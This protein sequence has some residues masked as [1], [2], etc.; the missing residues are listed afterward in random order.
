MHLAKIS[1]FGFKSFAD[2]VELSFEPG[3]TAVVG[4]NGCGKSNISDA[5]RWALGEQSAKLLR[6]DRMEDCIFAGNSRRKP[7]G[8][9]EVSLTLTRN[10]GELGVDYEEVNVTRRLYRSGESEYLLNKIPCRLRDIHDLFIDTGLAGEPYALIEQGSIGSVVNARPT[11]RRVLIEEAAGIM[12]YKTKKRSALNK[13]EATEQNLLRIRDVIA[14]VE[15]QRNSLK[16]QANKAERYRE[17][18]RRATELKLYLK[19]REHAALWDELQT[20]LARLSP[21]QETLTGLRAGIAAT[22]ADLESRRLQALA[23]EQ[24]VA[25]A[26]EALYALRGQIDRDEAELR[27]LTQ[28]IEAARQRQ[29][30]NEATLASLG[31]RMRGLL[32]ELESGASRAIQQEQEVAALEAALAEE[33]QR[34]REAE[35]AVES[36]VAELERLRGQAAHQGT[37]LALKRNELATLV[38]R[39]RQMTAQAER[40]R[41]NRAEATTQREGAE[42][43]FSA[44]EARRL[45]VLER[46]GT[47]AAQRETAQVDAE[48]AREAR[49]RLEAEIAALTADVERQRGRLASLHELK[50]QFADFE[51]GNRLLL[52]AG[53]DRRVAGI[54]GSLAEVLDVAPRHEKAL[55][56]ILGAHLQGVRVRTWAEAKDALAHLFRSGQGR[57]TLVS[58]M[59]TGQ[60]TWGQQIRE[61]LALQ[62]ADLPKEL[63]G[64]SEGL[65]LDLLQTPQGSEPWVVNLL[66]DAVVVSDLDAA[67]AIAR[68]LPGPFT[69]AT[70]AGEVLTHRGTLTGGTPAPQGLLAQ[71][72]EARELE[73]ALATSELGQAGLREA[74]S[75]VSE[76]VATAERAV[77]AAATAER[78]AELDLLAIEKDLA[79]KR[80]EEA[81]L[82]QQ[83]ELFGIELQ[84][85]EAD[86]DR[87]AGEVDGLR[88]A[89]AQGEAEAE[90]LHRAIAARESAVAAL[91]QTREGLAAQ[92]AEKRVTLASRAAQRD[93]TLRDLARMRH[94]LET[95][96]AETARLTQESADLTAHQTGL[97]EVRGRLRESLVSLHRDEEAR[98]GALVEVQEARAAAQETIRQLEETLRTRRRE[99]GEIAEEIASLGTKR[100]ELKTA[101]THLEQSLW[102]DHNVSLPE[103]R[104][105]FAESTWEVEAAQAELE[106]L[107]AKLLEL[108]PANLGALEEYQALC[109]RHEFLTS[110]ATDLTSSVAS[111]RQAIA[112]INRTITTLFDSTLTTVNRHFDHYWRRLIGGGSAELR[113]VEPG[114]GEATEEPGVEML[115]RIPGKRATVLSLLSGGERALAALALLL[116]LFTTR[117]SPF[118]VLDEVD[119]PLDDVNVERFITLLR[120]MSQ[121]SQFIVISHNKRTMEAANILY[122][123]TMEEEG[124]SKVISVRMKAAA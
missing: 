12:K 5:V 27:N 86:L 59:P 38:E 116:A 89:V 101:M 113:L 47:L 32:A 43:S 17:L 16:R 63:R 103:L 54:L 105:R 62:L 120:E 93:E 21:R 109:Q 81:R 2:K 7:L 97:E 45:E 119:A 36:G 117:P 68:E 71:R 53:R 104:E 114:E 40:L 23:Q 51:E 26:Q 76:D 92:L 95:A 41:L 28:Q 96:E 3:I 100:G 19:F 15:R 111:L 31:E 49:R 61:E 55:E 90:G 122:G 110:Q 46:Q 50:W 66:A 121:A 33:G 82:S 52:Q 18:D 83:L 8:L 108:G 24:A 29:G 34:L 39:S 25:T 64:Q 56:A 74:L 79:A 88:A 69:I 75:L 102:Q 6:G 84:A 115:L 4:P 42:A 80:A 37:Q 9:A 35:A 72:R 78:Q 57:A 10:E 58:P 85:V 13:L 73:E 70:L 67:Q 99:E 118:C 48:R 22:E 44:D 30:E 91:R 14:E 107:R 106:E 94:D 87:I 123:I 77:E 60:G 20:T 65:A 124:A 112:E 98:Q 11:D 1:L